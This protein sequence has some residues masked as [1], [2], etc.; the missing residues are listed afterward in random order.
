M[1]VQR[2]NAAE[3]RSSAPATPSDSSTPARSNSAFASATPVRRARCPRSDSPG[4]GRVSCVRC[5]TTADAGCRT[6]VPSSGSSSPAST[7]SRVDLPTP[8]GATS[9]TR[10]PAATS[11]STSEST[12]RGPNDSVTPRAAKTDTTPTVA[13]RAAVGN[14]I[15]DRPP[16]PSGLDA[17]KLQLRGCCKRLRRATMAPY[18]LPDLDYDYAD[19]EPAIIGE[20]NELHHGKHHA[21]YVKGAND[22]IEQIDEARDKEDLGS[23][24]GLETTL[25]FHLAGHALHQVWWKNLRRAGRGG[26][27]VLR[28]V[29]RAPQAAQRGRRVHPGLR[30]GHPGVGAGRAAADHPAA[31]GPP[32]QPVDRDHAAAR[33]RH[34][35]A[36]LLPA[37]PQPEGRLHQRAVEHRRLGRRQRPL[38]SGPRGS[39]RAAA[40]HR[41][42]P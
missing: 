5:A 31:E 34:L 30:L 16:S 2:S 1:A 3:Y 9:P 41:V 10:S 24:V 7:R 17:S 19:L 42:T 20:I 33:V 28:L 14:R 40:A 32:L 37:V 8:F 15:S 36:R 12:V 13:A 4:R 26:R 23:I 35:G 38:R 22:T 11:R 6:T 21:A 39:E 29:R 25:A 18:V 27:R